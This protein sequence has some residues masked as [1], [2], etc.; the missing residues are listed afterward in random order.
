MWVLILVLVLVIL[1]SAIVNPA[2]I[3][4][5]EDKATDKSTETTSVKPCC[6]TCKSPGPCNCNLA[7]MNMYQGM[8]Y[9]GMMYPGMNE[10]DV[11]KHPMPYY[12]LVERVKQNEK[13]EQ[14][15]SK[16]IDDIRKVLANTIETLKKDDVLP[17]GTHCSCASAPVI[18]SVTG[19]VDLED[20]CRPPGWLRMMNTRNEQDS[21]CKER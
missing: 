11:G 9:P 10:S 15:Q 3:E 18:D 17:S 14:N 6:S 12:E 7:K 1:F 2:G 16:H 4:Q 20:G 5:F 19:K 8:M 13:D 21:E